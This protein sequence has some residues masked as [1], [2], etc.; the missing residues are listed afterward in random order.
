MPSQDV[1]G[2]YKMV[3]QQTRRAMP[4]L[5]TRTRVGGQHAPVS[6]GHRGRRKRVELTRLLL[7]PPAL[8]ES[9]GDL[10]R[11]A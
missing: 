5:A 11:L 3:Y 6:A 7:Q 9:E 1:L 4:M 8:R 2:Q 10:N